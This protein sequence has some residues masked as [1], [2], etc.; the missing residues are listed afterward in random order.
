[1]QAHID[2]FYSVFD[3]NGFDH[4]NGRS[5]PEQ[6]IL[7][8]ALKENVQQLISSEGMA[9][10]LLQEVLKGNAFSAT[11]GAEAIKNAKEHAR[12]MWL[13]LVQADAVAA[14]LLVSGRDFLSSQLC[15][16][17]G[18]RW[19]AGTLNYDDAAHGVEI[20]VPG[21]VDTQDWDLWT[22]ISRDALDTLRKTEQGTDTIMAAETPRLYTLEGVHML[23]TLLTVRRQQLEQ[24]PGDVYQKTT[25][26]K[27]I[28]SADHQ[29][30]IL[31]H[32]LW[33]VQNRM[34]EHRHA[35]KIGA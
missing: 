11:D 25:L 18:V 26:G 21:P 15:L 27:A 5:R 7:G 17:E 12:A 3:E 10:N 1:M 22:R 32:K 16:A 9:S 6:T 29:I 19:E 4:E 8:P 33:T 14:K 23:I 2:E 13:K 28:V 34:L 35:E 31:T 20:D 30:D 24:H